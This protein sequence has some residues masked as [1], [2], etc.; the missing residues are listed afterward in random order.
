MSALLV[1]WGGAL[2]YG[3][4]NIRVPRT[5]N[6]VDPRFLPRVIGVGLVVLGIAHAVAVARGNFGDPDEGEDV[7]LTRPGDLR[8]FALIFGSVVLHAKLIRPLGWPIAAAILFFG[9][10]IALGA[11]SWLR[12]AVIAC[13]LALATYLLFAKGLGVYL[14]RGVLDGVLA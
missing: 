3:S 9:A 6:A 14:P 11:A 1:V 7:D 2:L 10:A 12:S 4:G 13:V 8:S 5:A